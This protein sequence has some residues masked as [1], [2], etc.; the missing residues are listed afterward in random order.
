MDFRGMQALPDD[1]ASVGQF[2]TGHSG[3]TCAGK[4]EFF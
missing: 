3:R 1:G 2:R 4:D